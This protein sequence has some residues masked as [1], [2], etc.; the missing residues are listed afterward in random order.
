MKTLKVNGK[1]IKCIEN[2]TKWTCEIIG[3]DLFFGAYSIHGNEL[4]IEKAKYM[5]AAKKRY[6]N[7]PVERL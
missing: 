5:L 4:I 2:G 3:E 6:E 7:K 1:I